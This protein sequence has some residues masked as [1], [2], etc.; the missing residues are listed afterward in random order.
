M[1]RLLINFSDAEYTALR[2]A[3]FARH[4]AIAE[5]VRE[6]VD[7]VYRTEHGEVARP[8]RPPRPRRNAE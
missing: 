1:K 3:A 7:A 2:Q 5:L 6:A 4:T 8:G